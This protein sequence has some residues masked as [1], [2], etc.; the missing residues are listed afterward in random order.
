VILVATKRTIGR[1]ESAGTI[2][3]ISSTS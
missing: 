2:V 1:V 3:R